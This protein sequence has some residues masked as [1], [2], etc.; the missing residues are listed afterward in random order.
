MNEKQLPLKDIKFSAR[1]VGKM[2]GSIYRESRSSAASIV[3]NSVD[4]TVRTILR[5]K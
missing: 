2:A 1:L 4:N 5:K 3:G